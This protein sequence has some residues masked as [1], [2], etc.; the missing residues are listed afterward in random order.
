MHSPLLSC[1][2]RYLKK[3]KDQSCNG[4]NRRS[5]EMENFIFETYK[6]Y[7]M[8]HGKHLSKTASDMEME[9]MCAYPSSKY[10]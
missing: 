9:T 8:P 7:G 3:L 2:E 5:S 6:N 1:L 4:K 10:A